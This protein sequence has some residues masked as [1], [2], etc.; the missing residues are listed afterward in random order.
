[1]C[2]VAQELV[3]KG[4][5]QGREQGEKIGEERLATLLRRLSADGRDADMQDAINNEQDRGKFYREYGL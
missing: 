2:W 3:E 5:K 1:M 4:E